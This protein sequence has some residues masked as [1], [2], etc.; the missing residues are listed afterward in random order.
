MESSHH[1]NRVVDQ[2][3][4]T[5]FDDVMRAANGDRYYVQDFLNQVQQLLDLCEMHDVLGMKFWL[6]TGRRPMSNYL[7]PLVFEFRQ[8]IEPQSCETCLHCARQLCQSRV[9]PADPRE[10]FRQARQAMCPPCPIAHRAY[11]SEQR[12]PDGTLKPIDQIGV[13][14]ECR[15]IPDCAVMKSK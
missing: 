6:P 1:L 8:F 3:A 13:P 4:S 9:A 5:R 7:V 12:V 15:R 2:R 10:L 14:F 11:C